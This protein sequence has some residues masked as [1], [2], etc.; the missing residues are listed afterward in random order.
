MKKIT[1]TAGNKTISHTVNS[2]NLSFYSDSENYY[3]KPNT[4]LI[5]FLKKNVTSKQTVKIKFEGYYGSLSYTLNAKQKSAIIDS[6]KYA[7]Y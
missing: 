2:S 5:N 6:L 4:S 1:I 7:G 3:F